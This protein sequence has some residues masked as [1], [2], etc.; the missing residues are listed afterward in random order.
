MVLT[1]NLQTYWTYIATYGSFIYY[2]FLVFFV[3]FFSICYFKWIVLHEI[4]TWF[5]SKIKK[6][7]Q[8][9]ICWFCADCLNFTILWTNSAD[10]KLMIFFLFLFLRKY[11]LT[12]HA[13]CLHWR[14]FA[15]NIKTCFLGNIRTNIS[16]C[17]QLKILPR[18]LNVKVKN[19]RVVII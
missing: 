14:Q 13:N 1:F 5:S 7:Y 8:F 10:D 3:C 4:S 19:E 17:H 6:C 11:D 9:V 16:I 2:I 12:C 18:M 15:W